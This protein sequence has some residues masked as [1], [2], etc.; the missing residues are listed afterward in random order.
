MESIIIDNITFKDR[1][2]GIIRI[3]KKNKFLFPKEIRGE[4]KRYFLIFNY[5]WKKYSANYRI[6]SK[7]GKSRSGVLKLDRKLYKN[8]CVKNSFLIQKENEEYCIEE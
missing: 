4:P 1:Q 5:K 7:D 8:I 3:L 6:G 2:K